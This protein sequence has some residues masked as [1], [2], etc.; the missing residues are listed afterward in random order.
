MV[1]EMN[2]ADDGRAVKCVLAGSAVLRANSNRHKTSC[3]C[4]CDCQ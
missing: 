2:S 3:G 1:L 4:K